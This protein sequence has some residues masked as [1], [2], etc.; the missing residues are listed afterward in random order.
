MSDAAGRGRMVSGTRCCRRSSAPASGPDGSAAGRA[1]R[2]ITANRPG[3]MVEIR[4]SADTVK[5]LKPH[6]RSSRFQY[7][8]YSGR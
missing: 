4:P 6:V 3:R 1:T 8:P 5:M 7:W 2:T